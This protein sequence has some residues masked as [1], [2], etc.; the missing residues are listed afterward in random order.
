[1]STRSLL[2]A[3]GQINN[4]GIFIRDYAEKPLY[5]RRTWGSCHYN[6]NFASWLTVFF[7]GDPKPPISGDVYGCDK[8]KALVKGG[9][10]FKEG[11]HGVTQSNK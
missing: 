5:F 6:D 2:L 4:G 7:I 9:P 10:F 11:T 3:A 1:L 8:R